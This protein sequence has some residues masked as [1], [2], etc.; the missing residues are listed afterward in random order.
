MLRKN[1]PDPQLTALL[2]V[3]T[4]CSAIAVGV[5]V[6][7]TQN[8][9][10]LALVAA[11]A[12]L[13]TVAAIASTEAAIYAVIAV[14]CFDGI[15]K[16]FHPSMFSMLLK[17]IFLAIALAHWIWDGMNGSPRISLSHRVAAPAVMFILYCTAQMFNSEN[18]SWALALAGL[19]S[20]CVWIPVFFITYDTIR[21]RKQFER[22]ILFIA[23][24]SAV[25]GVYGIVQHRIGFQHLYKISS[26]FAFYTA[27]AHGANVRAPGT[28]VHPG[29]AGSAMSFAATVCIGVALAARAFS[30]RQVLLLL[31]APICLAAMAATG[32]RAPLV[33]AAIGLMAF[34]LMT[35][36]AHLV[37]GLIILL[38]IGG[39]Q[40]E[41]YVGRMMS[42]RYSQSRLNMTVI[43][44]RAIG[45][46]TRGFEMLSLYPLGTGV[47]SGT[48]AG[49]AVFLMDEPMHVKSETAVLIENEV[50]R[51]MKELGL[52]GTA[53][54]LWLLWRVFTS[55]FAGWAHST[56]RDAWLASGLVASAL[57]LALQLMVGSSLYLAPGGIYF[58]M[59]CALASRIPDYAAQD[60]MALAKREPEQVQEWERLTGA[61]AT[62]AP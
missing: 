9:A 47:A 33:G 50:G 28:Y 20:W 54:F 55:A 43:W 26:S 14:A 19:R 58:W 3:G 40:A 15:I 38:L 42:A 22:L 16:G 25:T 29:T 21:T 2:T 7:M 13:G 51:A 11:I 45:P 49:R 62:Q 1:Q 4:V 17:D 10:L 24:I 6:M 27:F 5:G 18:V 59:A 60:A 61:Q 34:I 57:N 44:Q 32:S 39:W 53:L 31:A 56:G 8:N 23:V 48:G 37:V 36:R 12:T 35:R 52:P 30:L 46:F 41:K